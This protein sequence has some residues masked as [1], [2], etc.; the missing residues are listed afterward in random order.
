VCQALE[1]WT[2]NI[3]SLTDRTAVRLREAMKHVL[4]NWYTRIHGRM[5]FHA[6]QMLSGHGCFNEYLYRLARKLP[7]SKCSFCEDPSDTADHTL[8]H[9]A[10]WERDR[11]CLFN[12]LGRCDSLRD[13]LEAILSS[14]DKWTAL[15]TFC[16]DV[17]SQKEEKDRQRQR[18]AALAAPAAPATPVVNRGLDA[19]GGL[20]QP[21]HPPRTVISNEE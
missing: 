19:G 11:D 6:T 12:A 13:V 2:R 8:F 20:I 1:A 7:N 15:I 18:L 14:R 21:Q 5:T 3:N 10:A 16:T 4:K 9:C 17:M